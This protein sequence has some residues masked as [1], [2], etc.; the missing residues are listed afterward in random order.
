MEVLCFESEVVLYTSQC[1]AFEVSLFHV[2]VDTVLIR[3][4]SVSFITDQVPLTVR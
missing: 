2:L 4:P 1:R 3:C